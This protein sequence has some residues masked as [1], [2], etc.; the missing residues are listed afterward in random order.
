[1]IIK[2]GSGNSNDIIF[3]DKSISRAHA[4]VEVRSKDV[5]LLKDLD[6][7]N[8]IVVNGRRIRKK[9]IVA[10]D[11]VELG[12]FTV[13]S[14]DLFQQIFK[15]YDA[16]RT[17]FTEEYVEVLQHYKVYEKL[18]NRLTK[19]PIMPTAIRLGI[20]LI[21]IFLLLAF[22]NVIPNDSVRIGLIMSAGLLSGAATLFL[23]RSDAKKEKL[24]KLRLQF[25]DVLICPKCKQKLINQGYTYLMGKG[26]CIND[27][28]DAIY[29]I[30]T[31]NS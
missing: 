22:P 21:V 15:L 12:K 20:G 30:E 7:K 16:E 9:K 6:S 28:C 19:N 2:V 24:D 27:K 25:E 29:T 14:Q 23:S 17:D 4:E 26:K 1:M 11:K 3:D 5:L 13:D 10:V 8:G 18:K 31:K